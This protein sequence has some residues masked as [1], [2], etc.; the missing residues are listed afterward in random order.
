M[1]FKNIFLKSICFHTFFF[2]FDIVTASSV[3]ENWA[4]KIKSASFNGNNKKIVL[5]WQREPHKVLSTFYGF[6]PKSTR[7]K[8]CYW[9][10][11]FSKQCIEI[12]FG[13]EKIHVG[14]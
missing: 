10:L 12:L 11:S 9:T 8:S 6:L 5:P 14:D 4:S 2:F 1:A 3:P 13:M 7:V